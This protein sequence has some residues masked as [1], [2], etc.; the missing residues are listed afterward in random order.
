MSDYCRPWLNTKDRTVQ[1]C[2]R[3]YEGLDPKLLKLL[4]MYG[5]AFDDIWFYWIVKPRRKIKQPHSDYI[6]RTPVW[7][8]QKCMPAENPK[9]T[10]LR[11]VQRTLTD[12]KWSKRRRERDE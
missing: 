10:L 4:E 3:T 7:Q 8:N 6:K 2:P 5:E 9:T 1:Y 11:R 12:K